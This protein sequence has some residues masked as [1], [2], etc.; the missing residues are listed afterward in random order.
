MYD[1]FNSQWIMVDFVEQGVSN[2]SVGSTVSG[3][4]WTVTTAGQIQYA[5]DNM[6]G[7]GYT[8]ASRVSVSS[9]AA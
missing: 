3:I 5:T 9:I 6:T 8:G 4:T 2:L 7:T 1:R